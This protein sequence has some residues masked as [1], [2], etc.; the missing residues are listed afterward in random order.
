MKKKLITL[1][2]VFS[3]AIMLASCNLSE[4]KIDFEDYSAMSDETTFDTDVKSFETKITSLDSE[5]FL[6]YQSLLI[7]K[8]ATLR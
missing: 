4:K 1:A 6:F 3:N 2:L 5:V 8:R 7:E